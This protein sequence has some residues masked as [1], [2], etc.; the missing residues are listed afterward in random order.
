MTLGRIAVLLGATMFATCAS[1]P[2]TSG[3]LVGHTFTHASPNAYLLVQGPASLLIDSGY[4]KN[5]A[6]L[7]KDIREAGVDP[8]SLRA[9]VLTHGHADHAGGSRHFQTHFGTRVIAGQADRSMLAA[10]RNEP[11][12]PTGTLGKLR[13]STDQNA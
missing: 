5:G 11:L 6:A 2:R 9:I 10:G 13:H 1:G 3:S 7:E 4:E 12:C 8:R